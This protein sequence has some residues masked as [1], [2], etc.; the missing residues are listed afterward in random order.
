M[1]GHFILQNGLSLEPYA[2]PLLKS[3]GG[4]ILRLSAVLRIPG[5]L[6]RVV[7]HSHDQDY[8]QKMIETWHPGLNTLLMNHPKILMTFTAQ[9]ILWYLK[10]T[11]FINRFKKGLE[12][13]Q[14]PFKK[15]QVKDVLSP[16]SADHWKEFLNGW[17]ISTRLFK[18]KKFV[19]W[20]DWESV[21]MDLA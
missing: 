16:I 20:Q 15:Q 2:K 19:W 21:L 17:A 13:N 7:C 12:K 8:V 18:N 9:S 10:R 1:W 11:A 4:Q 14:V 5:M 6:E 3:L